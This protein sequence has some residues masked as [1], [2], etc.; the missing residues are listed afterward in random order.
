[1]RLKL[2]GFIVVTIAILSCNGGVNTSSEPI[3]LQPLNLSVS[4]LDQ[5]LF[6]ADKY[7][8]KALNKKWISSY[9]LLYNSFIS[10]MLREG[11]PQDPMIVYRLEKFL[12]DTTINLISK[13]LDESF[14]DFSPYKKELEEGFAHYK[15]YF[16]GRIIPKIVTF[17]SNF[18]ASTFPYND[19]LAIGLDLFIGRDNKVTE[20]LPPDVFPQ[21]IKEDMDK[22]Y[23]SSESMKSWLYFSLS[24][25]GEY[26]NSGVYATKK[27][28]LS[29]MIYHG[30]MM[31]ALDLMMPNTA[32]QTKFNYSKEEIAWCQKNEKFLYQNLIEFKLIYSRNIKEIAAYINPGSFTPGLPQDSPGGIGKWIG[33]RMVKQYYEENNLDLSELIEQKGDAKKILSFYRP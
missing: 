5:E 13:E 23:L 1:M 8:L 21:Y 32:I 25:T 3:D 29:S 31:L 4:R 2:I 22:E 26:A 11:L 20:M 14:L 10:E 28:F 30:K 24:P 17:Y 19:T 12:N 16:P 7:Q 15:H 33:Y 27:D 18:N 9:G 6:K